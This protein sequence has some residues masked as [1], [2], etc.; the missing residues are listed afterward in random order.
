MSNTCHIG[1]VQWVAR[2]CIVI[3]CVIPGNQSKSVN[4]MSNDSFNL[5]KIK[6][7]LPPRRFRTCL[8]PRSEKNFSGGSTE[9]V[10]HDQPINT[11]QDMLAIQ[12]RR[13][14]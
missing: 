8:V 14:L 11:S 1:P 12:A 6:I 7:Y 13:T 5:H 3:V 9:K 10:L 4:R 2:V